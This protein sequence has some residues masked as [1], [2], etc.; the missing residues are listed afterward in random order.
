MTSAEIVILEPFI[1]IFAPAPVSR[2]ISLFL[3]VVLVAPSVIAS[4]GGETITT[5]VSPTIVESIC[6]TCAD[7]FT[8]TTALR[9][10][11]VTSR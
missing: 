7:R 3:I 9:F 4:P 8:P 11:P 10:I 5:C 6:P 2:M 1:S